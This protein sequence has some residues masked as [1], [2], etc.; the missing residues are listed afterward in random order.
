M[1]SPM[2]RRVCK[3]AGESASLEGR[4]PHLSLLKTLH[5]LE[6]SFTQTELAL[7]C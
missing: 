6:I 2:L 5:F 1:L 3:T 7:R 4:R